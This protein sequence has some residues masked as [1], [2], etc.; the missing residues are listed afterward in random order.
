M[1]AVAGEVVDQLTVEGDANPRPGG[2]DQV[3]VPLAYGDDRDAGRGLQ[4][5]DRAGAVD[6][7]PRAGFLAT[8]MTALHEL[9]ASP[10]FA[11]LVV[12]KVNPQPQR[13]VA[14]PLHRWCRRSPHT[15]GTRPVNGQRHLTA[16]PPC[17]RHRGVICRVRGT[18]HSF[19][20]PG[21]RSTRRKRIRL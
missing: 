1:V 17:N 8:A 12:T 14:R 7:L 21:S 16:S 9:C 4:P 20:D 13:R 15:T 10:P 6:A 5:V 18:G 2:L 19:H 11:G 3:G